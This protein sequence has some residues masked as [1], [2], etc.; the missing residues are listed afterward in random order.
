MR[1]DSDLISSDNH[2]PLGRGEIFQ[3]ASYSAP[4]EFSVGELDDR[5]E[6]VH[7]DH[8]SVERRIRGVH[9][10]R[11][12]GV[13]VLGINQLPLDRSSPCQIPFACYPFGVLCIDL[14]FGAGVLFG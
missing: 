11:L 6:P 7:S 5:F 8:S 4:Q 14:V 9:L 1:L 10:N 13:S 12:E 3:N 2:M